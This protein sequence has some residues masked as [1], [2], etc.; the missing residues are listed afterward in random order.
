MKIKEDKCGWFEQC[1]FQQDF[2]KKA[3]KVSVIFGIAMLIWNHKSKGG[4]N[5]ITIN[6][7][8]NGRKIIIAFKPDH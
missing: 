8:T 4:M 7:N 3:K 5:G 1:R 6:Y 2:K